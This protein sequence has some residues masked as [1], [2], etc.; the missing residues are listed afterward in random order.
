MNTALKYLLAQSSG[1]CFLNY[2][3]LYLGVK[4][5]HTLRKEVELGIEAS[6]PSGMH[7]NRLSWEHKPTS[8][9]LQLPSISA[10]AAGGLVNQVHMCGPSPLELMDSKHRTSKSIG[11]ARPIRFSLLEIQSQGSDTEL[12]GWCWALDLRGHRESGW[13]CR[14]GLHATRKSRLERNREKSHSEALG[15]TQRWPQFREWSAAKFSGCSTKWKCGTPYS[16]A[17]FGRGWH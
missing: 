17:T 1:F 5:V 2:G 10:P 9:P 11:C 14:L 13:K 7:L 16:K 3:W 6:N 12:M 4:I 15:E 8:Q